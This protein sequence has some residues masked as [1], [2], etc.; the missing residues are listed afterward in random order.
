M[1]RRKPPKPRKVPSQQRSRETVAAIL[2]AA[3]QVFDAQGYDA[4]TTDRIAERAGVSVGTLYQYYPD[5][6]AILVALA[7]AHIDRATLRLGEL[8][9][10]AQVEHRS[11]REV[12]VPLVRAVIDEHRDGAN[13]HRVLFEHGPMPA[14]LASYLEDADAT[15]MLRVVELLKALP[16]VTVEEPECAA[17]LV[18]QAVDSLVHRFLL[19]PPQHVP[20]DCFVDHLVDMI[21]R[22][23]TGPRETASPP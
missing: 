22:Y 10:A 3:A 20:L 7:A 19:H 2:E 9:H 17:F 11:V 13:L 5:K 14:A 6:D 4:G 18:V 15:I 23:L 21:H 1:P 12:L 8:V 16:D